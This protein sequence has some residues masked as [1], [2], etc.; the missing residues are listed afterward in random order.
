MKKSYFTLIELLVV[1]AIIAILASMLLPA[2][3]KARDKAQQISCTSIYRQYITAGLVYANSNQDAF[4][5]VRSTSSDNFRWD[6]NL[7]FI[8]ILGIKVWD[9]SWG[10]SFW[11]KTMLCPKA[12]IVAPANAA[13]PAKYT[14]VWRTTG[15][16]Y[17]GGD[18][19]PGAAAQDRRFFKLTKIKRASQKIAFLENRGDDMLMYWNAP[20]SRYLQYGEVVTTGTDTTG[21]IAYR[22]AN[23]Y[24]TATFFDGHAKQ[25]S[26]DDIYNG[27]HP[28]E[29]VSKWFP[30]ENWN[31][32]GANSNPE[33]I[34][35]W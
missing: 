2:L 22:H 12:S 6:E 14:N 1:I 34:Q 21:A 20:L 35:W 19:L 29:I 3:N 30:Y 31:S 17:G 16:T 11:P 25:V 18:K 10:R 23:R 5:P 9:R 7:D 4:V 33:G 32:S 8:D 24:A 26:P 15:L 13:C 28:K 27:N